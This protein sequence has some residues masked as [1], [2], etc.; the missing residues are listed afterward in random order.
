M[1][2]KNTFI[3]SRGYLIEGNLGKNLSFSTSFVENQAVFS[4][5]LDS[6]IRNNQVVPGQGYARD[7]K[8]SGYDYAIASG[9]FSLD[10][11]K[12]FTMQFGHYEQVPK[13]IQEQ[14]VEK[15]KG[16]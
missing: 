1:D 6:Y 13:S 11:S 9:Y 4:N 15:F 14:I 2:A 16:V 3:N 8:Q 12:I 5:Y 10:F 7:F